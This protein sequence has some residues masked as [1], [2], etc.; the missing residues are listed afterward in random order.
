VAIKR[1]NTTDN[2]QG[3][4]VAV[5]MMREATILRSFKSQKHDNILHLQDFFFRH[6][7]IYL[8][9]DFYH[10]NL[11]SHLHELTSA[12][13]ISMPS[14]KCQSYMRQILSALEFCHDRRVVHRD[15]KP[16]NI[17]LDESRQ[18]LVVCDFGMAKTY[19]E[20]RQYTENCV[21]AWYRP[22]EILLGDTQYGTSV[23]I[24][25]AG[26][27]M[28]EMINLAPVMNKAR[29]ELDC[30][31]I[32]FKAFGT[33][34]ER[35]WP[36]VT[37][38][39]NFQASYAQWPARHASTILSSEHV[40]TK[41]ADLL[42]CMLQLCPQS[43]W[44][45]SEALCTFFDPEPRDCSLRIDHA[46]AVDCIRSAAH[47][48]LEHAEADELIPSHQDVLADESR[49]EY[50]HTPT[51]RTMEVEEPSTE[52]LSPSPLARACKQPE[53]LVPPPVPVKRLRD[54]ERSLLCTETLSPHQLAKRRRTLLF[55]DFVQAVQPQGPIEV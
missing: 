29:T 41:A 11:R 28:A 24:W 5:S 36:G 42:N 35:T 21:T 9:F 2:I 49:E 40:T 26:M 1:P 25:S 53:S 15:L 22:P 4:G 7:R 8:V 46:E 37:E 44:T 32:L 17:L 27:V 38:L 33:P 51:K 13:H 48:E 47:D 30:L 50:L 14:D 34:N 19:A 31:L 39:P 10:C 23:D 3:Q 43:R 18:Q 55:D 45:A 6:D 52:T 16:D 20:G 12:G 54:R